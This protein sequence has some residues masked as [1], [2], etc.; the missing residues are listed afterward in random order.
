[1]NTELYIESSRLDITK[2]LSALLTFSI[3]DVKN[4]SQRS[5][6]WSR[7]IVLP[8]TSNNNKT[9]GHVFQIGRANAFNANSPNVGFNFNASKRANCILFQDQMQTFKG[10]LR[11]LQI[12][13]SNGFAGRVEYEVN[14]SGNIS[15]LSSSLTGKLLEDLNFSEHDQTFSISNIIQSWNN[16]PGSGIY[17]P[18]L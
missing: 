10:V 6:T 12:N 1:M 7:T 15:A 13:Y 16:A 18:L 8:G 17:Y 9:F 11:L 14:I 2:E 3:D 4:F 5:T